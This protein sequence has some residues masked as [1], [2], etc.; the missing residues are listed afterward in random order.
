MLIHTPAPESLAAAYTF[1]LGLATDDPPVPQSPNLPLPA[2]PPPDAL[3]PQPAK[4][5]HAQCLIRIH[6]CSSGCA[7]A[8]ASC[9]SGIACCH[10]P[11]GTAEPPAALPPAQSPACLP[12]GSAA[13]NRQATLGQEGMRHV[14]NLTASKPANATSPCA[15]N[16][17]AHGSAQLSALPHPTFR[18]SS[19]SSFTRFCFSKLR[20]ACQRSVNGM[21]SADTVQRAALL[22]PQW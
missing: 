22:Q 18:C 20:A 17:D 6:Q 13:R 7:C 16:L 11:A 14:E 21:R 1:A 2:L 10:L 9:P 4:K 3:L 19:S 8:A 12:L 15:P 5:G